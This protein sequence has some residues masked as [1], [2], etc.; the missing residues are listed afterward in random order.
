VVTVTETVKRLPDLRVQMSAP[1]EVETGTPV[2]ILAVVSE[3]NGDMG[4][5]AECEL[6]V[7]GRLVDRA[8]GVWIDAGDAVTCAMSWSFAAP[9]SYPMEVR[10]G[11]GQREWDGGNNADSTTIQVN[12]ESP[13]F[14]TSAA[15]EQTARV[16]SS[17]HYQTWRDGASMLAGENRREV[18]NAQTVQHG[19]MYAFMPA[20]LPGSVDV[21]ASMTSGGS[22]VTSTAF[23]QAS[24]GL[25][26]VCVFEFDGRA[27]L[28]FCT[29][30]H[31]GEGVTSVNYA[32]SAG[33]VTY[34]SREF[35]RMWDQLTSKE[36]GVY[37]WN[38]E[39]GWDDG[40]APL[41]DDW[42]FDVTINSMA[43][44]HIAAHTLRLKPQPPVEL[45]QPYKCNTFDQPWWNYTMTVCTGSSS[46]SASIL[47]L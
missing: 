34:H 26:S 6:H 40:L 47:G 29:F 37:H 19:S 25:E 9:G 14:Y 16:D 11:T 42:R 22:V 33:S 15:F 46:R 13:R 32:W 38:Y 1:A 45:V 3:A 24:N 10:V 31:N 36:V 12:G 18:V 44:E 4:V 17:L 7:A 23:T 30:T 8:E 21:R 2:N 20:Q 39:Y 27:M 41:G 35:S 28:D 5:Y 43:G